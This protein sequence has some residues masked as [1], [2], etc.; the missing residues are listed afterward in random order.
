M[1]KQPKAVYIIENGGYTELTYEEFCRREQICP[2]YADKLF[3][4][5]YGRLMEVSFAYSVSLLRIRISG[6]PPGAGTK[7]QSIHTAVLHGIAVFFCST[8][9]T[10]FHH[11]FISYDDFCHACASAFMQVLF[12]FVGKCRV[13]IYTSLIE[14]SCRS[15]PFF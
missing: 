12:L 3:L 7:R 11:Y 5:L 1:K 14:P 8:F 10:T 13:V 6:Y 9:F 15:P 2:L 4:P